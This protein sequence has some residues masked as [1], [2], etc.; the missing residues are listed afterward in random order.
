M[1]GFQTAASLVVLSAVLSYL[2]YRYV[3]LPPKIGVMLI[4]LLVSLVIIA[5]G[6]LGYPALRR[7]A[8]EFLA[9][10][11]FRYTLLNGMLAFLLFAGSLHVELEL[12]PGKGGCLGS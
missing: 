2:N 12:V 6:R 8:L 1:N 5:A 4:A 9:R 3:R 11:D 10:I 7:D